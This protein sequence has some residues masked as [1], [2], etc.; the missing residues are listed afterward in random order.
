MKQILALLAV[1]ALVIAI[2]YGSW[3]LK[4]WWNYK[5]GYQSH[6]QAEVQT[7][8]KPVLE[9]ISVLESNIIILNTRTN[10]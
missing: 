3:Q 10:K 7:A 4:R 8:L 5:F 2:I 9:R 1:L 6:V